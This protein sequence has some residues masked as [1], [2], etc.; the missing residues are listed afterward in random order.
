MSMYEIGEIRQL[1][2]IDLMERLDDVR[3]HMMHRTEPYFILVRTQPEGTIYTTKIITLEKS[4]L[5]RGPNGK[6]I[7]LMATLLFRVDNKKGTLELMWAFP[8]DT[9][10]TRI[11]DTYGQV[12]E[13]V[14]SQAWATGLP[15]IN[16]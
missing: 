4:Q 3:S 12:I 16:S 13:T 2:G 11:L 9:F 6:I 5:P 7:P 8:R 1:F 15:V 14:A 10:D